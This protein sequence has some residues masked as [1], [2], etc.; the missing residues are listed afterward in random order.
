VLAAYR[1][2]TIRSAVSHR[3]V[4]SCPT[5]G[6]VVPVGRGRRIRHGRQRL[7]LPRAAPQGGGISTG[8]VLARRRTRPCLARRAAGGA[9]A[10]GRPYLG[11][12]R[13]ELSQGAMSSSSPV[14]RLL[15]SLLLCAA[16]LGFV[17]RCH[18]ARA[19]VAPGFVT[20]SAASF[21]PGS[22]CSSPDPGTR[23]LPT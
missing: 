14:A 7:R 23:I 9:G 4:R 13:A 11:T 1:K 19:A 16:A 21:K 2:E 6:L 10:I 15:L 20:V 17:P 3:V 8:D 22:T 18:G 5:A 12:V